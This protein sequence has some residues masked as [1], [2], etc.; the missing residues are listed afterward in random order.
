MGIL[1]RRFISGNG[2]HRLCRHSHMQ[3]RKSRQSLGES[4]GLPLRQTVG[5]P[6]NRHIR[7]SRLHKGGQ[8][9]HMVGKNR[10]RRNRGETLQ[11]ARCGLELD[12]LTGAR[13]QRQR[14]HASG[15][16]SGVQSGSGKGHALRPLRSGGPCIIQ[17]NQQGATAC[18]DRRAPNRPRNGQNHTGL[19]HKAQQQHPPGRAGRLA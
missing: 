17:H 14:R 2:Q 18:A 16:R 7:L 4:I 10:L 15:L 9:G 12:V 3:R 6:F 11:N 19:Q 8:Q 5:E 13:G 1:G